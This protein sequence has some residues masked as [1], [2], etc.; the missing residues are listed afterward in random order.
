M[1]IKA[2]F[3]SIPHDLVERAVARHTDSRGSGCMSLGGFEPRCRGRTAPWRSG[4]RH[5]ARRR[6]Q[7]LLANLFLHYAFDVWMQRKFPR[8]QFER[9]ADDAIV[10]CRSEEQAETVL[11]VI[12]GRFEQCGLELHPTK[13]RDRLLQGRR[14]AWGIRNVSIRLSWVS[15][16]NLDARKIAGGR[17]SALSCRR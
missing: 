9:Y 16:S 7:S 11:A 5:A 4:R 12:R 3:D 13:T 17:I 2:F 15:P 8:V 6:H 1:D 14:P 10:H